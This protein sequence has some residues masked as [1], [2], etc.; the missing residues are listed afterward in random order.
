MR[1]YFDR[2]HNGNGTFTHSVS[3]TPWIHLSVYVD[4]WNNR[5]ESEDNRMLAH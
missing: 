1:W 4:P 3:D 5:Y 2:L